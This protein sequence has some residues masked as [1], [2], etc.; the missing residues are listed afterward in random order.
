MDDGYTFQD[1]LRKSEGYESLIDD[2]TT[3]IATNAANIAT[4]VTNIGTNTT[5][6][7][8][9]ANLAG[10]NA[11]TG[12]ATYEAG[13]GVV[14][15]G[16][17]ITAANTLDDYEEGTWTPVLSD[18]TNNATHS[19]QNGNYTKVGDR[20]FVS[21]RVQLSSLGSVSGGLR[22]SG[23][24]FVSGES[25]SADCG[26]GSN[27]A[28]TAGRN[29]GGY[30]ITGD[31]YIRLTIWDNAIGITILQSGELSSDGFLIMFS[32]YKV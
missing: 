18:G 7:A 6:I 24:P 15:N 27:M 21:S 23:L 2:N 28:I 10:D 31:S 8:L 3:A 13:E 29:V 4:N 14:F 1:A 22:I 19:V 30:I 5:N 12:T 32:S 17:A 11:Y 20:V 25:A 9:K 26:Y 16:D